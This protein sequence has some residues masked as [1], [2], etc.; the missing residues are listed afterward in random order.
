MCLLISHAASCKIRMVDKRLL[1]LHSITNGTI[2][3]SCPIE[4]DGFALR[5]VA[6]RLQAAFSHTY[7]NVRSRHLTQIAAIVDSLLHLG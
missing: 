3:V 5:D 2:F 6:V 4:S 1:R 7:L